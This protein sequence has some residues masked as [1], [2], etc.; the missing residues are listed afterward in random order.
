MV[1]YTEY[2]NENVFF[3]ATSEQ[4]LAALHAND[5]LEPETL[6]RKYTGISRDLSLLYLINYEN[7]HI[8]FPA[9]LLQEAKANNFY[10]K[11]S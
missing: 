3:I 1:F 4:T 8:D 6:P 7:G 9:H 11:D 2:G 10:Q 5:L